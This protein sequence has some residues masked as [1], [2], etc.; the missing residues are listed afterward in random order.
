MPSSSTD[1]YF[2]KISTLIERLHREEKGNIEKASR[3]VANA[4]KQDRV[5]HVFGT[6]GHSA[7]GAQEVFYRAG[8]LI[9]INPILDPGIMLSFGALRSTSIE[10]IPGYASTILKFQDIR[11]GDPFILVN[12]YGINA[13]TID[14]CLEVQKKGCKVIAITSPEFARNVPPDHPARHPS[15]KNLFEIADVVIDNKMPFGDAVVDIEGFTQKVG[16]SSTILSAF[17]LNSIVTKTVELLVSEGVT[18]PVWVSANVPG[19]EEHNK[20]WIEKY[21]SRIRLL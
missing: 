10:R 3:I 20:K 16:P 1:K 12:A 17:A 21:R 5:I 6:G 8:G 15:K 4:I 18:P 9:P 2:E 14:S 13:C 7:I 11:D 19:G